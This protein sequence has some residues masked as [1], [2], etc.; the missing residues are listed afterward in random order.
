MKEYH[1]QD[2]LSETRLNELLSISQTKTI[3]AGTYFIREGDVPQ[4][5][6]F[7]YSGL[8]RYVY[9]DQNGNELT[10]G[11]IDRN[12]FI[13]S[14][15][16]MINNTQSY[17]FIETLENAEIL[18]I[19]YQKWLKLKDT[20][21]EWTEF[22]LQFVEKGFMIK[23]KRE[24]ELLLL[25]AETRYKNFLAEF[26]NLNGRVK[27]TVIASFLGIQPESLSRIRKKFRT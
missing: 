3:E 15:S 27:Q 22:L 9:I 14:Y 18:E 10:K 8:F 16:A 1:L 2:M 12:N 11:I 6:A 23:E 26:P 13:C 19:D 7:V 24:R 25:D 21:P 5:F 20:H 17:Y 4:K